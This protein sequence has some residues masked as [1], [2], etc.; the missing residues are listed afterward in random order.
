VLPITVQGAGF[1]YGAATTTGGSTMSGPPDLYDWFYAASFVLIAL[2]VW[3]TTA[4]V[5]GI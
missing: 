1:A 2:S 4:L 5:L 3:A